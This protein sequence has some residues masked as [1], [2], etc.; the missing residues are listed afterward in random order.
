MTIEYIDACGGVLAL[1]LVIG[2]HF[3]GRVEYFNLDKEMDTKDY[4]LIALLSYIV[5]QFIISFMGESMIALQIVVVGV[6]YSVWFAAALRKWYKVD[7]IY[8]FPL[9][10][11]LGVIALGIVIADI[12]F[13]NTDSLF[14]F[15]LAIGLLRRRA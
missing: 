11:R 4:L 9:I 12:I 14:F 8:I 1:V 2:F 13:K 6:A 15:L 5:S 7:P 3:W 10:L